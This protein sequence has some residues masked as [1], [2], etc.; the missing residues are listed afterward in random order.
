MSK[1]EPKPT[2]IGTWQRQPAPPAAD[3]WQ[4]LQSSLSRQM[5]PACGWPRRSSMTCRWHA[6]PASVSG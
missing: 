1:R 5:A 6:V 4:S 3:R 2:L